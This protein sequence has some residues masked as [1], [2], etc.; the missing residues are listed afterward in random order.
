MRLVYGTTNKAK[1]DF[2]KRRV[3][4]LD[5][6]IVSLTGVD[7]PSL[8]I[9]ESGND[10]LENARIKALAYY[11]VLHM[12][13][14]S[15]DSGLYIDGLDDRRQPG[16]HVRDIDGNRLD[17]QGMIEYY[18]AL[19]AKRGGRLTARWRNGICLVMDESRVYEYMGEDIASEPFYLVSKPHSQRRDGFPLDSLS[20]HIESGQYYY[21]MNEHGEKHYSSN[22]GFAAFFQRALTPSQGRQL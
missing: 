12:P 3:E 16:V 11:R 6:E 1:L 4:S 20:V 14:F 7:A 21:G 17:D 13:V 18:S 10:P 22:N 5:V 19:A 8:E 15:C 2:M 9:D